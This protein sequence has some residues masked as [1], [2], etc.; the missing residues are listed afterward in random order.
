M[1]LLGK[2]KSVKISRVGVYLKPTLVEVAHAAV[3][4]KDNA[5]YANKFNV[6]SKRR[7]R[8]VLTL[9]LLEKY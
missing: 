7:V 6:I 2:K 8:N 3:K 4:D 5:Y 1:N 9:L